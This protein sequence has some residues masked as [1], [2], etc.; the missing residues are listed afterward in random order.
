[1]SVVHSIVSKHGGYIDVQSE[2]D[3]STEF[4]I[5]L[6]ALGKVPIK[7][8]KSVPQ[9][10]KPITTGHIL[11]MDD[12]EFVREILT[13]ILNNFGYEVTTV[14]DGQQV[15]EKYQQQDFSLVILDL[16][17]PGDLGGKETIKLLREF[18][19]Q[20]KAVVSSGYSNDPVV[21]EYEKYGFCGYLNK[22]YVIKN[23][24]RLPEKVSGN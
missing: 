18:D 7:I 8:D 1:M 3:N 17:I 24:T 12:E 13:E 15:L 21:A 10:T 20:V 19:P 5:F 4:T 11:I 16:T 2:P 9:E 23:I 22:P 14:N 6:P